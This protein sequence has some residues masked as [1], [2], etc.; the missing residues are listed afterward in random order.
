MLLFFYLFF[1]GGSSAY[2]FEK[3]VSMSKGFDGRED[4]RQDDGG[5]TNGKWQ[6]GSMSKFE[7][8]NKNDD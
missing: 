6:S 7:K 3:F 2:Y 4:T 5:K 8:I 1:E